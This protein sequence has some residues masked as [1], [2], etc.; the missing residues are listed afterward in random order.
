MEEL[1]PRELYLMSQARRE[2]AWNHTAALMAT[3]HNILAK[4]PKSPDAFHP[5]RL[6]EKA[7]AGGDPGSPDPRN[8]KAMLKKFKSVLKGSESHG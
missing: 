7:A 2:E 1:T 6:A 3:I 5:L 8:W 4:Q